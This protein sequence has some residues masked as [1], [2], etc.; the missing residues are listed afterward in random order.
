MNRADVAVGHGSASGCAPRRTR[1]HHGVPPP[2][3]DTDLLAALAADRAATVARIA[4][5][6][7][8]FDAI[9]EASTEVATDDEHDPEG[10][11]IAYERAQVSAILDQARRHLAGLDLALARVAAGVFGNCERCGGPIGAE[12]LRAQPAA[13]RCV[14]CATAGRAGGLGRR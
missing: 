3:V 5:L 13:T 7:G 11:T 10:M 8:N 14:V 2:H 9:V 4:S 6:A 1:H 12:R